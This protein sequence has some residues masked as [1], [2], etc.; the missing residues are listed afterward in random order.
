MDI[1]IWIQENMSCGFLDFV[2]PLVTRLSNGGFIWIAAAV[3]LIIIP[4]TRQAGISMAI[5]LALEFVLCDLLIKPAVHRPRPCD[6]NPSVPLLI[7]RP[8]GWSFPSGHTGISF[9]GASSLAFSRSKLAFP[10][11]VLAAVTAFSRVYLFVH[12]PTDVAAGIILGVASAFIGAK[13]YSF[14]KS[15][16]KSQA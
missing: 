4:K 3:I 11:F 10:A 1:L 6:I 13:I 9:A 12:Y 5:S 7:P 8:H 15:I 2:L 16:G 14:F